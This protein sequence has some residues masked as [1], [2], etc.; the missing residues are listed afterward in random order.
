MKYHYVRLEIQYGI[1]ELTYVPTDDNVA[2][3]F[4]NPVTRVRLD[5]LL[6]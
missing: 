6:S 5:R 4:T 3:V 1:I 2:D